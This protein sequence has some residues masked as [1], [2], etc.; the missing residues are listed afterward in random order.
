MSP[1][2]HLVKVNGRELLT[3][4]NTYNVCNT[5]FLIKL[6]KNLNLLHILLL[7]IILVNYLQNDTAKITGEEISTVLH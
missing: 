5:V 6:N 7:L 2:K 1:T 4:H 3:Q